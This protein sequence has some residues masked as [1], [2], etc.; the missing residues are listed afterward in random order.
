MNIHAPPFDS[1]N[2]IAWSSVRPQHEPHSNAYYNTS[3]PNHENSYMNPARSIPY[4]QTAYLRGDSHNYQRGRSPI[5]NNPP[6]K[7][8]NGRS[9]NNRRGN[10]H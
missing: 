6:R 3:Q 8:R 4:E 7:P 9:L 1:R 2:N 10:R 5:R